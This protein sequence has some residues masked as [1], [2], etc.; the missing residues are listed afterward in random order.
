MEAMLV[1]RSKRRQSGYVT[2]IVIWRLPKPVPGSLHKFK[3]RLFFGRAG[4]RIIG[5]D[6][7]RGKGD[8]KHVDGIERPYRFSGLDALERD[9]FADIENWSTRNEN[10]DRDDR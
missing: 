9:F 8:D 10:A 1:R 3:Y 5:Y 7:E 4:Q 2:E 6:N